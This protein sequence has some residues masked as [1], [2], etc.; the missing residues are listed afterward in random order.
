MQKGLIGMSLAIAFGAAALIAA[1]TPA[2]I[3]AQAPA[4]TAG[5]PLAAQGAQA[6]AA[7]PG[8]RAGR[9]PDYPVRPPGD[10]A[11][12]AHGKQIFSVNCSFCHGPDARGGEGGPNLIRSELVMSDKNGELIAMV[13]Q[14]GRP[15][16]GM[17]QFNLPTSDV[18]DVA[19]F[20]HSFPVGGKVGVTGTVNSLVGDAKAGQIYFSGAG[21]CN[22]CHSVTGDLAGIGTKYTDARALQDLILSGGGSRGRGPVPA[23]VPV[24][25]VTVTLPSGQTF[26][27]KLNRLDDFNVSL[28]DSDGNYIN[29]RRDG[30]VPKVVVK[31]PFQPHLDML[32]TFTDS[33]IH[34][35]TAY[36]V[37]V[38]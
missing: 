22:T 16:K 27:G 34:N 38:K 17:P 13:V 6:A 1:Q 11:A 28:I 5:S 15:D 36:L 4:I 18:S 35:L 23:N 12:I 32:R 37:T 14:N 8:G 31:N 26:Q 25:T 3:S 21:K 2:P 24:K 19:A 30:D 33:D 7:A 29:F 9:V 10:P 20:I